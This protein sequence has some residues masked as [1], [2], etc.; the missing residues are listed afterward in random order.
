MP[1]SASENPNQIPPQNFFQAIRKKT[2]LVSM[3]VVIDIIILGCL[4]GFLLAYSKG[5]YFPSKQI[6]PGL[7][8][9][10]QAQIDE[11]VFRDTTE[12]TIAKKESGDPSGLATGTHKLLRPG[13]RSQT[14]YIISSIYKLDDWVGKKVKVLGETLPSDNVGWLLNVGKIEEQK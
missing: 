1:D 13:G 11:K 4:A 7:S 6:V 12:G 3:V 10:S 8:G 5:Q 9:G 14:V 2:L